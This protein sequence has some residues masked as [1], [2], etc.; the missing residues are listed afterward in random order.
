MRTARHK[1]IARQAG[2]PVGRRAGRQAPGRQGSQLPIVYL[3]AG[4]TGRGAEAPKGCLVSFWFETA[5]L[6]DT[7]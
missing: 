6:N 7:R 3:P 2:G 5:P 1:Q 4:P